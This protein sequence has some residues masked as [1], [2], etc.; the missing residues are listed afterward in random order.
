MEKDKRKMV[1]KRV[2]NP[3]IITYEGG[4][5]LNLLRK[6]SNANTF[7]G[8]L[9]GEIRRAS[10]EGK[11]EMVKAL[12]F[13]YK[14]HKELTSDQVELKCWKGKSS[15]NVFVKPESFDVVTYQKPEQGAV[16]REITRNIQKVEVNHVLLIIN[17]LNKGEKI[18][19]RN[20]GEAYYKEEWD[21]VFA[22][23]FEHTELNLILR[24]LDYYKITHYRGGYTTVLKPVREIQ[25]VLF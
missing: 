4:I 13:I 24:L 3:D 7:P 12:E 14:K 17:Q 15:F 9:I 1:E 6:K 10:K 25:E 5:D 11:L 21:K 2:I 19:T 8:W 20:I 23:R 22:N 18:P 16:P